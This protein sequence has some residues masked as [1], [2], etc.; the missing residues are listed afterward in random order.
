MNIYEASFLL[1]QLLARVEALEAQANHSPGATKM[2]PPPVATDEELKAI[3]NVPGTS[4]EAFRAIYNLGIEHGQ[5][6]SRKV[7]EPAPVAVGLVERV[8]LAIDSALYDEDDHQWH[9]GR[10]AILEAAKWLRK[11]GAECSA[12]LLEQEA[13]R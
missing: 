5:A 12:D 9:E 4:L 10:A 8:K 6:R 7:A 1:P 13:G 2:V 3:W 11:Q